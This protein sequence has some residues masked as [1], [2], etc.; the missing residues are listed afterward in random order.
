MHQIAKTLTK[1]AVKSGLLFLIASTSIHMSFATNG[2][3]ERAMPT[4]PDVEA[5]GMVLNDQYKFT[6][7]NASPFIIDQFSAFDYTGYSVYKVYVHTINQTDFVHRIFGNADYPATISAPGGIYN[8]SFCI[9]ATSGGVPPAGFF[10]GGYNAHEIDSWVGI[11]LTAFPN[12]VAGEVDVELEETS[13]TPW[14][15]NFILNGMASGN[16]GAVDI[17]MQD[18]DSQGAWELSS[19]DAV[20]GYAGEDYKAIVMQLTTDDIFTWTLSAEIWIEGDSTNTVIVTQTFDGTSMQG[21]IIEGCID[22]S[23]CNYYDLATSDN[24]TCS[25]PPQYYNCAGECLSDSDG[26]GICDELEIAG[27]MSALACNYDIA[28]TDDDASCV[29]AEGCD[30]C[31]GRI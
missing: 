31:S 27:C 13:L 23:A 18:I 21:A 1:G 26:D 7:T 15:Q 17:A 4:A 10:Y 3:S 14:S 30:E 2:P 11:G 16:Y 29:F 8:N 6:Q 24:G 20:N 25:Y 5:A 9:G 12:D 22:S 28:A 19:T